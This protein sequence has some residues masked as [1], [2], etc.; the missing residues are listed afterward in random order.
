MEKTEKAILYE[1]HNIVSDMKV[2]QE[3]QAEKINSIQ[4]EVYEQK[5]DVSKLKEFMTQTKLI[6]TICFAAIGGA[7]T[8]LIKL[9]MK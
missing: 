5:K 6:G 1:I 3:V 7:I 4:Q 9:I 8:Y 2:K